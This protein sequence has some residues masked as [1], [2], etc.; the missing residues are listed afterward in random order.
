MPFDSSQNRCSNK[1]YSEYSNFFLCVFIFRCGIPVL[2]IHVKS[3]I[4]RLWMKHEINQKLKSLI[5][6]RF[7]KSISATNH[8]ICIDS[9]LSINKQKIFVFKS[10]ANNSIIQDWKIKHRIKTYLN[11]HSWIQFKPVLVWKK[12]ETNALLLKKQQSSIGKKTD[13]Q[14]KKRTRKMC[15]NWKL[16]LTKIWNTQ[17]LSLDWRQWTLIQFIVYAECWIYLFKCQGT[18]GHTQFFC[19]WI[20]IWSNC[21][22]WRVWWIKSI[23]AGFNAGIESSTETKFHCSMNKKKSN[24]K[25][26]I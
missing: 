9:S 6:W 8:N 26:W 14:K 24:N 5:H 23:T 17:L 20:F 7:R 15:A 1:S 16:Q 3:A 11:F 21:N 13:Y 2:H 10:N 22:H 12:N 25:W 4:F 18:W 19:L